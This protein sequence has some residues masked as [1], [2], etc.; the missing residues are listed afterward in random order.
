MTAK[1]DTS[2]FLLVPEGQAGF[3][4]FET[5]QCITCYEINLPELEQLL[6]FDQQASFLVWNLIALTPWVT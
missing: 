2:I 3:N 4:Y 5:I 6:L 1:N